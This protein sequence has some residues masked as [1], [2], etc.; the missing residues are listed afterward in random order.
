MCE[1]HISYVDRDTAFRTGLVFWTQDGIPG[2]QVS[3]RQ[4]RS[5]L[6]K[7]IKRSS[8]LSSSSLHILPHLFTSPNTRSPYHTG[9][10]GL[11]TEALFIKVEASATESLLSSI[12]PDTSP[13]LLTRLT[14]GRT[15]VSDHS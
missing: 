12:M 10:P 5:Y 4:I 3:L 7:W 11:R 6:T 15:L 2:L 8:H 13:P 9:S 14:L 1:A